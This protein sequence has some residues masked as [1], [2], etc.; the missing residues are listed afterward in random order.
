M[1]WLIPRL[2]DFRKEEPTIE[3]R[4]TTGGAAA[5]FSDDWSCGI[6]LGDGEWP[7]LIA[8]PLFCRRFAAGVRAPARQRAEAARRSQGPDAIAGAHSPDD[9]PSWLKAAGVLASTRADP[10]CNITASAASR[11]RRLGIHDGHPALYD[12]DSLRGD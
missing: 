2:A 3:V 9:W 6:Q 4:I 12:D 10:S 7:G 8:E 1:R 5:K 11:G